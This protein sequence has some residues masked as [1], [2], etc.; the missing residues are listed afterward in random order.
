[1]ERLL[2]TC[3]DSMIGL[4]DRALMLFAWAS[5][6]RR[7]S[8]VASAR[9]ENLR[10]VPQGFLYTLGVSKTNQTGDDL[11]SNHKP[12]MGRAAQALDAWLSA[13]GVASGAIFRRVR[14]GGVVGSALGA[15][16]VRKMVKARAELA[17]LEGDFG[18][19][20]L[21]SGF[22]TE[23]GR[24]NMPLGET[25][26]MTGHASVA[27]VIGYHRAGNVLAMRSSRLLDVEGGDERLARAPDLSKAAEDSS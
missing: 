4:R 12:V 22:V 26:V 5:G 21:R 24:Q 25:M 19:H 13:S 11:A 17:G 23:S 3:D 16:A 10:R 15:E 7:R 8:E 18:A 9:V 6:G 27:S 20:S 2:E 1:L 14:R